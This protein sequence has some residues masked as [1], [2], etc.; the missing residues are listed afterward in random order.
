M[1]RSGFCKLGVHVAPH[2]IFVWIWLCLALAACSLTPYRPLGV[3]G[4]YSDQEIDQGKFRIFVQGQFGTDYSLVKG[5]FERR[6]KEICQRYGSPAYKLVSFDE[7]PCELCL[8]VKPEVIGTI[9]CTDAPT[10]PK[11]PLTTALK[12]LAPGDAEAKFQ[13]EAQLQDLINQILGGI[14]GQ[15][16]VALLPVE[17]ATKAGNTPLGNYLTERLTNELYALGLA[18]VK[19]VERSQ[20]GKV[21][22]ELAITQSGRF[23]ESSTKQIGKFLGVDAVVTGS[24]AE[25]GL[26]KV[27]INLRVV[28]VETAEILGVGTIQI[29]R[30][31]VQQMLR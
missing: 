14:K 5:Y 1:H 28:S 19:V 29:P 24:Y 13:F 30:S 25:I 22:E 8:T 10:E 27:E 17:D 12:G 18:K 6:A 7:K 21:V 4:G 9:Q 16:R 15:R 31:G 20:M 11:P 3:H 2:S 23:D 26:Q